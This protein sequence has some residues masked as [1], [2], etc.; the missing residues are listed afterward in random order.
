MERKIFWTVFLVL[1]LVADME[2]PLL[3]GLIAIV[4]VVAL[5]FTLEPH[6]RSQKAIKII[7]P[8]TSKAG[9]YGFV[10]WANIVASFVAGGLVLWGLLRLRRSRLAAYTMWDHAL[11]VDIFAVLVLVGAVPAALSLRDTVQRL[12]DGISAALHVDDTRLTDRIATQ[13]LERATAC[14]RDN[15]RLLS[16]LASRYRLGVVSNFY[17]NL[18]AVCADLGLRSLFRVIVDSELSTAKSHAIA[19]EVRHTLFHADTKLAAIMVHI[20]P[21]SHSGV[22]HHGLTADHTGGMRQSH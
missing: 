1:S 14:A 6:L 5:V 17:G 8:L 13:F 18:D 4:E 19:E 9:N 11:L 20:D 21:S 22:D 2:L 3:W 12:V 10:E 7:T 15:I 16:D